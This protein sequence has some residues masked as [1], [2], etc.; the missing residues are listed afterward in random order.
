[1]NIDLSKSEIDMVL[2]CLRF[3]K[4][5]NRFLPAFDMDLNN[6]VIEKFK[7]YSAA[8]LAEDCINGND[9]HCFMSNRCKSCEEP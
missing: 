5:H 3:S 7:V 4:Q 1:M 8:M 9:K 2:K 6:N